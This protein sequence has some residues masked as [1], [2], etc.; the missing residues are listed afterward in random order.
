MKAGHQRGFDFG[1]TDVLP[2]SGS[3]HTA[4]RMVIEERGEV[5]QLTSIP[6]LLVR[7][8]QDKDLDCQCFLEDTHGRLAGSW[9]SLGF[10]RATIG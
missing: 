2:I 1:D 6:G 5:A 8:S 4:V 9:Q 3:V 7:S 10:D